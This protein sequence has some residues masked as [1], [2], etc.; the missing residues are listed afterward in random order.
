MKPID[1]KEEDKIDKRNNKDNIYL[2]G[3]VNLNDPKDIETIKSY[4]FFNTEQKG[5]IYT[6]FDYDRGLF[7]LVEQSLGNDITKTEH[8][9]KWAACMD[10]VLWFKF[11]HCLIGKPDKIIIYTSEYEGWGR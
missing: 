10:P 3:D 1:Q 5:M 4:N 8:V 6:N 2:Y 9:V 7:T 11:N